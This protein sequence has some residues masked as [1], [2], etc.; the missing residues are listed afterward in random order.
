MDAMSIYNMANFFDRKHLR[1]LSKMF[2]YVNYFLHNSYIPSGCQIGKTS[3]FA[4]GG[5]GVVIHDRA[6]IGEGCL[7]GQGIT[8]GGRNGIKEVPV[9]ENNV[10]IGAGAR[11]LGNVKIG[12]DTIIGPN[13]VVL[14]DIPSYSVAAGVPA[15]IIAKI[16]KKSFEE[17]YQFYMGPKK[18]SDD[19]TI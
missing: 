12:H 13:A 1:I 6:R 10:Y 19:D 15:K 18:Y 14:M 7:I 8:I 2:F 9:I 4:Y 16:T 11:I 3:K 5:I 17:K